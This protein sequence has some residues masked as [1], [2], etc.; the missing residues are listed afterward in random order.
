MSRLSTATSAFR[1]KSRNSARSSSIDLWSSEMLL[2]TAILGLN[3]AIEPSLSSTSLMK[4][5]PPPTTALANGISGVMKFFIMA[6]FMMVGS[7]PA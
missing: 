6:P 3:S 7:R 1:T 4:A 5:S 2:S